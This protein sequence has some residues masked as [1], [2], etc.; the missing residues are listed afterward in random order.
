MNLLLYTTVVN[1]PLPIEQGGHRRLPGSEAQLG[2]GAVNIMGYG[3]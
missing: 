3:V 2:L 1:S